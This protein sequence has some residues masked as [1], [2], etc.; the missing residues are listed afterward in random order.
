MSKEIKVSVGL[1]FEC[2]QDVNPE[3]LMNRYFIGVKRSLEGSLGSVPGVLEWV[4][5]D[6]RI[7]DIQIPNESR[8]K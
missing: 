1:T 6:L 7:N 8:T 3:D 5:T 2:T 4:G